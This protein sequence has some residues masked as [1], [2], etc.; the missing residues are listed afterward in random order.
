MRT[1]RQKAYAKLNLFLDIAGEKDGFHMLDSIVTT[2]SI[3]DEVI[4]TARKDDK[5][6]LKTQ[7]SR[8]LVTS[9]FDN[10]VYRAAEAFK[11][12]Y[13]VSGA[14]ITLHK[15]IPVSSGM[16][17][18]SADIVATIKGLSELY[19]VDDA[20]LKELADSLGSDAGYLLTGGFAR[21]KGRG[22]IVEKIDFD[23]KLHFVVACATGGVNT[24]LCYKTYDTLIN[25]DAHISAD[26][27]IERLKGGEIRE[28]DFYNAL[29]LPAT[30][31]NE[32]VKIVYESMRALS[33]K[34]VAM[35]GSGSGVFGIFDTLEL[36]EWAA[37]KLKSVTKDVFVCESVDPN[38]VGGGWF[39]S[40][41]LYS[42]K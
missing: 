19:G 40:K 5:I 9:G 36:C 41:N 35:T 1:V 38:A 15:F 3:Y 30:K 12:R 11:K 4:I 22:E 2:I 42:P 21:I 26:E 6:V 23:K 31:I 8:Y 10:N 18:S 34:G 13:N 29:Y 24:A 7:G 39:T 37:E 16:G 32:N 28:G 14:D 17:G 25:E 27:F 20:D 33:P